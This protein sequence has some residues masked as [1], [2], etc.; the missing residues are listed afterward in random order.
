MSSF[1]TRRLSD[2]FNPPDEYVLMKAEMLSTL[3]DGNEEWLENLRS[4]GTPLACLKNDQGDSILHLAATWGNLELVKSIVSECPCLLL[5]LN[6]KDQLPL[7]VA[8]LAGHPAVVEDL[9]ASVTFFS[10]RLAEED[11]EILN[12]IK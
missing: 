1:E 3:S 12:L 6:S 2:L 5:E 4:H 10:A 8:A 11:R 7:H 9:V